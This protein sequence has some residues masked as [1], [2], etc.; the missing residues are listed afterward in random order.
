MAPGFCPSRYSDSMNSA[1]LRRT[2]GLALALLFLTPSLPARSATGVARP[3]SPQELVL[4]ELEITP[5][6]LEQVSAEATAAVK[7][8]TGV[9]LD[10]V[11]IRLVSERELEQ[12]LNTE[13]VHWS[14]LQYEDG[15]TADMQRAR[16]AQLYSE[17]MLAKFARADGE[18]LVCEQNFNDLAELL[19]RPRLA[20]PE[21]LRAVLCHEFVHA[22]DDR[23]F[24][25]DDICKSRETTDA[26]Q[27]YAAVIE[28]HAQLL[29]RSICAARGWSD[30]FETFTEAIGLTPLTGDPAVDY[31]NRI[32]TV[33]S[34]FAYYDG[35]R[36]VEALHRSGGAEA[37]ARAFSDPPLETAL[38]LEPG[39]YL[40]PSTRPALEFDIEG[41]LTAFGKEW[42]EED[43]DCMHTPL[44]RPQLEASFALLPKDR[45]DRFMDH[46]RQCR[47][48]VVA[49]NGA[50]PGTRMVVVA[51]FELDT[52]SAAAELLVLEED[53]MRLKDEQLTKGMVRIENANYEQVAK[54][55]VR[56]LFA[57][58]RVIAGD[59]ELDAFVLAASRGRLVVEINYLGEET[60]REAMLTLA[61]RLLEAGC[62]NGQYT[63]G[64]RL[65]ASGLAS[66]SNDTVVLI[67]E[68]TEHSQ[69]GLY[70][71]ANND[72]SPGNIWG[73]GLQCAGGQ[74]KRLGVRFSDGTGY[75][76]TSAWTTP[77]SVKAG[78]VNAGDTKY[79]Q[80]WYRNPFNS[81]CGSEFNASNGYMITW[82]P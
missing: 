24:H 32:L 28:G 10:D 22:A 70:F 1:H 5:E 55:P 16:A 63:S 75:S 29:T 34:A 13:L 18:V 31:F 79:Y 41:T 76:D 61:T 80:L 6:L 20:T 77:I 45:I 65:A 9:T 60:D 15:E 3:F 8:A 68:H 14:H 50:P 66:I 54:G 30:A 26:L 43:W 40:D 51:L 69:S 37:V 81:P 36:F 19:E 74:L 64:A 12:L 72:L 52:T 47:V 59:F 2:L 56:G 57:S 73:D 33:S 46:S 58:K 82:V 49:R 11:S 27:A 42:D 4:V 53:L 38:I 71:Q 48:L 25:W 35:E 78:N 17:T 67:G 44:L 39:W 23:T 21:V 62:A 7:E